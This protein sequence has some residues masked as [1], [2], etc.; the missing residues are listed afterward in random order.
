MKECEA[1]FEP[2]ARRRRRVRETMRD[3][4]RS[5]GIA[6]AVF[7][8]VS[9]CVLYWLLSSRELFSPMLEVLGH[10]QAPLCR[11]P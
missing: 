3:L 4:I 6:V 10:G 7:L 1:E 2:A 8:K 11:Q 9:E 5:V